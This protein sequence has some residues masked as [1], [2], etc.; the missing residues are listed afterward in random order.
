MPGVFAE[1]GRRARGVAVFGAGV[2]LA[3]G[4]VADAVVV[5][6]VSASASSNEGRSSNGW[7]VAPTPAKV[8]VVAPL[9]PLDSAYRGLFVYTNAETGPWIVTT[10]S[11]MMVTVLAAMIFTLLPLRVVSAVNLIVPLLPPAYSFSVVS[12]SRIPP[13]I[14]R[15]PFWPKAP[16]L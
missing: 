1:T 4:A 12:A 7:V 9:P 6:A 8:P 16:I 15:T 14:V 3:V 10:M 2:L 13:P 5:A 11:S